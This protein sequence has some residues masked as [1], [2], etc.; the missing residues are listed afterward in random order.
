MRRE[1][2]LSFVLLAGTAA[3]KD[4]SDDEIIAAHL[5]AILTTQSADDVAGSRNKCITGAQAEAVA[6]AREVGLPG[7]ADVS[8]LCITVLIRTG[9]DERLLDPYETIMMRHTGATTDAKNLPSWIGGALIEQKS[10]IAPLG[11]GKGITIDPSLAFD[12]GFSAA[13]LKRETTSPPMPDAATLKAISER[14]L[15]QAENNL[16]L[17]YASGYAHAIQALNGGGLAAN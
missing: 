5:K 17:C 11:N 3:A 9:R 10:N 14:C 15:A 7:Y 12:A 13:Y 8:D 16:G 6:M 1:I 2:L 4:L